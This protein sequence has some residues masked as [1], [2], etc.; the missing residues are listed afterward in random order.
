MLT[1]GKH[2]HTR[3]KPRWRGLASNK[4]TFKRIRESFEEREIQSKVVFLRENQQ[5]KVLSSIKRLQL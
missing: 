2:A 1:A 5:E 4:L 3:P